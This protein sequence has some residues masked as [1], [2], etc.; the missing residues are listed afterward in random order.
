MFTPVLARSFVVV[1]G[2]VDLGASVSTFII[3]VTIVLV[4]AWSSFD[5]PVVVGGTAAAVCPLMVAYLVDSG[6]DRVVVASWLGEVIAVVASWVGE[7]IVVVVS[8]VGDIIAVVASWLGEVIVVAASWLGE[9]IV[10]VVLWLGEVIAV[11]EVIV[12]AASWLGDVIAVV[13]SWLGVVA[14]VWVKSSSLSLSLP[15]IYRSIGISI[16]VKSSIKINL[17]VHGTHQS[18]RCLIIA[19][20]YPFFKCKKR[21]VKSLIK[22]QKKGRDAVPDSRKRYQVVRWFPEIEKNEFCGVS[23]VS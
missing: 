4:L 15:F 18:C 22:R 20:S 21:V 3:L 1:F 10:V 8:W 13:A 7:V 6:A 12:V 5:W 17:M 19:A 11:V 14:A 23:S 9:V 2:G 16:T